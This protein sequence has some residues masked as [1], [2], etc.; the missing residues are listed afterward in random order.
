MGLHLFLIAAFAS[1]TISPHTGGGLRTQATSDLQ[2]TGGSNLFTSLDPRRVKTG[3]SHFSPSLAS[4]R[5]SSP[6][7]LSS[8][9][10]YSSIIDSERACVN[11]RHGDARPVVSW[12]DLPKKQQLVVLTLARLSEPLVQT[13]LHVCFYQIYRPPRLFASNFYQT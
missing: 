3:D 5:P 6:S 9:S 13:S 8:T 11:G 1:M 10:S 4:S 2:E 7:S 12:G